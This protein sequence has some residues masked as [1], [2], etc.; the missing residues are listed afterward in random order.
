MAGVRILS[1]KDV[2]VDCG[3]PSSVLLS[4]KWNNQ[5]KLS[6]YQN[7]EAKWLIQPHFLSHHLDKEVN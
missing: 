4:R 5:N 7:S 6:L 2:S 3:Y 1:M